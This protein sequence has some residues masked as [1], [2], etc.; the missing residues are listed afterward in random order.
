MQKIRRAVERIRDENGA[1]EKRQR[2]QLLSKHGGVRTA[3]CDYFGDC[4]LGGSVDLA[5]EIRAP[6]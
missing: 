5:H 3:S 4:V 6:F 1:V 2:R